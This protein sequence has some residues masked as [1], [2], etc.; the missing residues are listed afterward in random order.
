MQCEI[1]MPKAIVMM[2][3]FQGKEET[4]QTL[5]SLKQRYAMMTHILE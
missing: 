4:L 1:R 2:F 5:Q 3:A